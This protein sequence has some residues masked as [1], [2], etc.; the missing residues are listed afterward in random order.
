MKFTIL[1]HAGMLVEHE[2]TSVLFDP[3]LVGSCYWRSWWN[4][5][6]VDRQVLDTIRPD[7]IYL[8]H[9]H[10][11]HF[12]SPSL[13]LFDRDTIVLVPK[14]PGTRMVRDL[15]A[16]KMENVIEIPHGGK[17]E[18][19][20]GFDLY[21]YQF[22]LFAADSAAV[23][24]TDRTTLL[25]ANDCKIFGLPL[26]TITKKFAKIDF[27]FRS[28][29]SATPLP[30][31][32]RNY[33]TGFGDFRTRQD[34]IDEFTSFSLGVGARYAIPFASNHC[35]LHRET[36]RFNS[37]S[38]D[39]QA[40]ADHYNRTA[41]ELAIRS[42]AVVM[43]PG[44]SWSDEA[45]FQLI[46]FDYASRDNVIELMRAKYAEKY[47][48]QY[49]KEE[50]AVG[51]FPAFERYFSKFLNSIPFIAR[52]TV[53]PRVAFVA[54]EHNSEQVFMLDIPAKRIENVEHIP[55]NADYVIRVPALVL[56]DCARRKMFS[57]W[58]A[59]KRLEIE[60]RTSTLTKLHAFFGAL[61]LYE[62][63]GLPLRRNLEMR[64]ISIWLRRWR[65]GLEAVRLVLV[66]K[67]LRRKFVISELYA[68]KG[69]RSQ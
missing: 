11:D 62:N 39:P 30:Y 56:N 5:P 20:D 60:L 65:E 23:L 34:Y 29:S 69:L 16:I 66:Y 17:F 51:S 45:G 1:S 43:T 4:F 63:G 9:L 40:V 64:N 6:E 67:V 49:A 44:S 54:V 59:S 48:K 47:E 52:W 22:G 18:L 41:A 24:S 50:A 13:R 2:G 42:E 68:N 58:G 21:S 32:I 26:K 8:T 10:W 38:V 55:E 7:Y 33:Q 46:D 28:H 37:T 12:H 3:W 15:K 25:N 19:D 14:I 35:F 31:T 36:V 61:D 57:V 53:L 27:C